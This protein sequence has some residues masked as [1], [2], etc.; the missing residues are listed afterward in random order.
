MDPGEVEAL[1]Q[2][3]VKAALTESAAGSGEEMTRQ[4]LRDLGAEAMAKTLP[5]SSQADVERIIQRGMAPSNRLSKSKFSGVSESAAFIP[6]AQPYCLP[7][8]RL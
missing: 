2:E 8:W 4:E 6:N 1:V 3:A 7:M 5:V